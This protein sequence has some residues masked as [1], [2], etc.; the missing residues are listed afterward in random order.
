M[1]TNL[2]A[3]TA[4]RSGRRHVNLD[5]H[6]VD[7]GLSH[8]DIIL[9]WFTQMPFSYRIYRV[10][11]T[12]D[13]GAY[14]CCEDITIPLE[15]DDFDLARYL[16]CTEN[17]LCL[18]AATAMGWAHAH[19]ERRLD[20]HGASSVY[21]RLDMDDAREMIDAD[22]KASAERKA[23]ETAERLD[24]AK[25]TVDRWYSQS[26]HPE[27][28]EGAAAIEYNRNLVDNEGGDGYVEHV[29]DKTEFENAVRTIYEIEKTAMFAEQIR[30]WNEEGTEE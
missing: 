19:P 3:H 5:A 29:V 14:G 28:R 4:D 18:S 24:S 20:I 25:R 21:Y 27:T 15:M 26:H 22:R 10:D 7:R 12:V 23:R 13:G 17:E 16:H 9:E 2:D 8:G 11:R 1:T 30:R 6:T